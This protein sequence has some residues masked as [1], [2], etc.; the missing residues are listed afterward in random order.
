MIAGDLDPCQGGVLERIKRTPDSGHIFGNLPFF[1]LKPVWG[2]P[3][4]RT[5]YKRRGQK[6]GVGIPLV[7]LGL[8]ENEIISLS[9]KDCLKPPK[10]SYKNDSS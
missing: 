3:H 4:V 5:R 9:I 2:D 7:E 8:E 1:L 10:T 6:A